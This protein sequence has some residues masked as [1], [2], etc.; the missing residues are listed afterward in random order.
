MGFFMANKQKML[1][2]FKKAAQSVSLGHKYLKKKILDGLVKDLQNK[3]RKLKIS[4]RRTSIVG[5]LQN[6]VTISQQGDFNHRRPPKQHKEL[7]K[8]HNRQTST[9]WS[10]PKQH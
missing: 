10:P 1:Q 8:H 3:T 6:S 5:H 4:Q 2:I 9:I 7:S